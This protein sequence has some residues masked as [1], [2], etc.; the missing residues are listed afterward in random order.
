MHV[1][2]A[3]SELE[4]S[5]LT[6][7]TTL[8]LR[9]DWLGVNLPQTWPDQPGKKLKLWWSLL[10]APFERGEKRAD[11]PESL[12]GRAI[13]GYATEQFHGLPNGY[14]SHSIADGYDK[15]FEASMLW[16]VGRARRKMA[17]RMGTGRALDVGCGSGRLI[18]ELYRAGASEVWGLDPSPYMLKIAQGRN[19]QALFAQGLIEDNSFPDA[20]FDSAGACFVFHELPKDVAARAIAE[21]YRVLKPGATLCITE[22][23]REHIYEKNP[24]RLI[25]NY[26]LKG[27]YFHLLA[28][29]VYEPFLEDW[30]SLGDHG[31]WL[32]QAGFEVEQKLVDVPFQFLVA[33]KPL[34]PRLHS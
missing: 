24:L 18:Q 26:G 30:Q 29:G 5:R 8:S 28:K 19:P 17:A 16:R 9:Q 6:Q 22:P 15:G 2:T 1:E 7:T 21:L 32:R 31:T 33:R 34:A 4:A 11:V 10:R 14:Y 23:C 27:I 3:S 12:P 13:P 25:R 20:F